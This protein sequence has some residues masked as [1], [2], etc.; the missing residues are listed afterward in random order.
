MIWNDS[1]WMFIAIL[2]LCHRF[3]VYKNTF[4]ASFL[5]SLFISV[6]D[7]QDLIVGLATLLPKHIGPFTAS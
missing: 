6:T 3:R 7:L 2:T 4:V 1:M 5:L